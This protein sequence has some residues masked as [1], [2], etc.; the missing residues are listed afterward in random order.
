M[1]DIAPRRQMFGIMF[2][3]IEFLH[4][5]RRFCQIIDSLKKRRN[6]ERDRLFALFQ[7][8]ELREGERFG[9]LHRRPAAADDVAV[10]ARRAVVFLDL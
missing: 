6:V 7:Q 8:A 2:I 1:L 3:G 9:H 5:S 4:N 10:A